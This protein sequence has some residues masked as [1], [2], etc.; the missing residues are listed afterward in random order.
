[1]AAS[2]STKLPFCSISSNSSPPYGGDD[3]DDDTCE[4]KIVERKK[5]IRVNTVSSGCNMQNVT[6]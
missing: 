4:Y 1:M 5:W 3:D 6:E 2:S